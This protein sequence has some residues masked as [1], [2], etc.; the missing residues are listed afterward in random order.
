MKRKTVFGVCDAYLET[1][2]V[3]SIVPVIDDSRIQSLKEKKEDKHYICLPVI[4]NTMVNQ[5]H[6]NVEQYTPVCIFDSWVNWD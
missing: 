6:C 4:C 2:I 5:K 1:K 3:V